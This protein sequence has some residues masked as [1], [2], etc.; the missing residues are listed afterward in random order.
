MWIKKSIAE[1]P[2]TKHP[3]EVVE[4]LITTGSITDISLEIDDIG[5]ENEYVKIMFKNKKGGSQYL[6][7]GVERFMNRN[8]FVISTELEENELIE[9]IEWFIH[10]KKKF[11]FSDSDYVE[12]KLKEINNNNIAEL[13]KIIEVKEDENQELNAII[14]R[15][16]EDNERLNER[17][18]SCRI[19]HKT[20]LNQI[21]G[22][23]GN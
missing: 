11:A 23:K 4:D 5:S 20:L 10:K 7:N 12:F 15:L 21:Y 18:E 17:I 14:D 16:S 2:T 22:K 19:I 6:R 13:K 1:I 3:L 8:T 9:L